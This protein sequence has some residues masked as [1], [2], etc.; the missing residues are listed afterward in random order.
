MSTVPEV[1]RRYGVGLSEGDIAAGLDR[2]LQTLPGA[3][4]VPLTDAET[5][6]LADHAGTDA[7]AIISGWNPARERERRAADLARVVEETIATTTSIDQAAEHLGVD[8]SRISHRLSAGA[9][10]ATTVGSR[11]RIPT[12]QFHDGTE[13]PGLAMVVAAIPTEAHPL[14]VAA[15][16]STPQDEL[17][18]HTPVEHL[19]GGGGPAVVADLVADLSRW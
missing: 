8:R 14:D 13:L 1:L 4:A 15:L 3:T 17:A 10:Y 11:R 18:G 9:L 12:W 5:R 19:V 2:A 6:F 16:M 7:A